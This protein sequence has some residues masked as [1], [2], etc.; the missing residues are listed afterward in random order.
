VIRIELELF[1]DGRLKALRARGHA[2]GPLG[3]NVACAAVSVLLRTAARYFTEEGFVLE[4]AAAAPGEMDVR[5]LDA[6]GAGLERM[7]G[8]S[9]LLLRGLADLCGEYPRDVEVDVRPE[10]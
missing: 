2:N 10:R 7:R 1:A 3:G 8:A 5:L 4:G 9:G 6:D